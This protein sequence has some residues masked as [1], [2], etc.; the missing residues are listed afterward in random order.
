MIKKM[1]EQERFK[2]NEFYFLNTHIKLNF[3]N[4]SLV[5][6]KCLVF[7]GVETPYPYLTFIMPFRLP[8]ETL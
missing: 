2:Y 7:L 6:P 1:F 8:T 3:R 4:S 5:F